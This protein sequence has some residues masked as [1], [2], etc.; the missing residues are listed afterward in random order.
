MVR[1]EQQSSRFKSGPCYLFSFLN[2]DFKIQAY[3]AFDSFQHWQQTSRVNK[4][5]SKT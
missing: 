1:A 5:I 3:C 4:N 2:A